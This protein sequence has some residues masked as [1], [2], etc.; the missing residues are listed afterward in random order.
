MIARVRGSGPARLDE[1]RGKAPWIGPS[2]PASS[3]VAFCIAL[4]IVAVAAWTPVYFDPAAGLDPSW[5]GGLYMAAERGLDHGTEIVFTYGP[6]GFLAIGG[7][8]VWSGGLAVLAML[9]QGSLFVLLCAVL[10][11]A[12]QRAFGLPLAALLTFAALVIVTGPETVLVIS[13]ALAMVALSPQ[14]PRRSETALIV[15][16]ATLAALECLMKLSL[17]PVI[18]VTT[19]IA[20]VGI[21]ASPRKFG[22]FFGLFAV[23]F[24][25]LW[26]ISGQSITAFDDYVINGREII[27]GYSD[28]F[29]TVFYDGRYVE[30][31][32]ALVVALAA[33][34]AFTAGPERRKRICAA[35][36]VLLVAFA[37][38]KESVVR[39]DPG[40]VPI[41]LST[42]LLI[43]LTLRW[44]GWSLVA[45]GAG[46]VVLTAW[47]LSVSTLA[48]DADRNPIEN[49]KR[50]VSTAKTTL[51]AS[52]R[53]EI[54]DITRQ[55]MRDYYA[56][57]ESI[58]RDMEGHTVAIVPFEIS[59]AW[60]YDL[61][62][63]PLPVM[64][65]YAAYT[66][67]LDHLNAGAVADPGGPELILRHNLSEVAGRPYATDG[68]LETWETPAQT[69]AEVCNFKPLR[70][71]PRWQLLERIPDRCGE[72]VE[73]GS[74]E[75]RDGG[76]VEVPASEGDLIIAE[77]HGME[78][79]FNQR[80]EALALRGDGRYMQ[81]NGGSVYRITPA[82]ATDGFLLA[83]PAD[84]V[85]DGALS[86]AP[87]ATSLSPFG[88]SGTARFDFFR[89]P[90]ESDDAR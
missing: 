47:V 74:V 44:R 1:I 67:R 90:V 23:E 34:A 36:C 88:V 86:F 43:W 77:V 63:D 70:T 20:L 7:A 66:S 5:H 6:L 78:P 65:N 42:A 10:L 84:V 14:A 69:V 8:E 49:A 30:P 83:G 52:R 17:G 37:T 89:I 73:A 53:D 50:F 68:R 81:I 61:D 16:G 19:V 80:I 22:A 33:A 87:D 79:T 35:L 48:A 24:A 28:G 72:P 15:I 21:G 85:G 12:M 13:V 59:V 32:A 4:A 71:L 54:A 29:G 25:V 46:A 64:Q 57:P 60:A 58:Q 41:L 31:A 2:D 26:L 55:R 3:P 76:L 75:V 39:L 51:S 45:M 40:H 56:L 9:F 11:Y 27:G 18:L 62:W 82:T 38:F